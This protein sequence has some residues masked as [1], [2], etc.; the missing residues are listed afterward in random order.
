VA[1]EWYGEVADMVRIKEILDQPVPYKK[2]NKRQYT[3][4]VGENEYEVHTK[5]FS[6]EDIAEDMLDP[7]VKQIEGIVPI[8]DPYEIREGVERTLAIS[9]EFALLGDGDNIQY[10]L[11]DT[12]NQFTVLSTVV[13]IAIHDLIP[14]LMSYTCAFCFTA[15]Q[16]EQSRVKVYELLSRKFARAIP[17]LTYLGS[18]DQYGSRVYIFMNI[19]EFI[20]KYIDTSY[21]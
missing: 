6:L 14:D 12:G 19:E 5:H 13:D 9:I 1:E 18:F 7:L 3:F 20:R 8:I 21:I 17:E 15:K 10:D 4:T 16:E 11:T 2:H